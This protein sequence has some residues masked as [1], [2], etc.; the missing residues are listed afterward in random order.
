MTGSRRLDLSRPLRAA[1]RVSKSV[2]RYESERLF[3]V[4]AET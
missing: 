1:G 3:G 4:K 2:S